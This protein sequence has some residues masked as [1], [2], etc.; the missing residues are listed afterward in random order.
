MKNLFATLILLLLQN[1]NSKKNL[2]QVEDKIPYAIDSVYFQKWIGG[3]ELTGSGT[4]FYVNFKQEL[5]SN[6]T[7]KNV[8]FGNNEAD[9]NKNT[10]KNYMANFY[11]KPN[12]KDLIL[13][14]DA[15]K[16]Y[17]NETPEIIKSKYALE[18]NEAVLTFEINQ[19]IKFF[20]ISK[21][22]EKEL[23][24]YPSMKPQE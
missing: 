18:Q 17:G 11:Q 8:Y 14:S 9:F 2:I 23:I 16:E 15:K 13:D 7:L 10:S 4:Y 3:Q 21:I 6:V 19:E 24:A 22:K 20:K 12:K 1:C 5:P